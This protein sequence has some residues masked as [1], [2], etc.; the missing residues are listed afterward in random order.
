MGTLQQMSKMTKAKV[1]EGK[2]GRCS[3]TAGQEDG[4]V[5][6]DTLRGKFREYAC[7][8]SGICR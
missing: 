2:R 3:G 7:D 1:Q 5:D 8:L 4:E 6:T